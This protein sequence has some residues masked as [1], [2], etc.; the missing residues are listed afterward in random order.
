MT[1]AELIAALQELEESALVYGES[2]VETFTVDSVD[3]D[4]DGNVFI[5]LVDGR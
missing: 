4:D 5:Y 2:E 3:V 1:V